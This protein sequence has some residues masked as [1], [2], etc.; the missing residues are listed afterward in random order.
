MAAGLTSAE[1]RGRFTEFG[2][3]RIGHERR[4][5]QN[6]GGQGGTLALF[7]AQFKSPIIL[8]LVG[9]AIVSLFIRDRIDAALI[10]TIVLIVRTR[11]PFFKSR[12]SRLLA[13]ATIGVV[14]LAALIPYL[15]FAAVLGFGIME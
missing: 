12:P 9:A 15:P 4:V 7:V 2:E 10:L 5:G 3:N 6:H 14:I 1:A 11:R 8:I 13:L